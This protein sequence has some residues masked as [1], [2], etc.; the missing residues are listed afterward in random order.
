M[1]D[2]NLYGFRHTSYKF[3][4]MGDIVSVYLRC[5]PKQKSA[6]CQVTYTVLGPGMRQWLV[7]YH[8]ARARP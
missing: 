7:P 2:I 3:N 8:D 4:I 1:L 5:R 6:A